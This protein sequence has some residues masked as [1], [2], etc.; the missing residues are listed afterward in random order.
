MS[1]VLQATL[2]PML[3]M[4]LCIVIGFIVNKKKLCPENTTTVLSKLENYVFSPALILNTFCRY[5]SISSIAQQYQMVLFSTLAVVLAIA[6]AYLLGPVFAKKGYTRS[7]YHYALTFGNFGFLGNAIVPAILGQD[8]LYTYMLFSLPLYVGVYTWGLTVLIPREKGQGNPF[9]NLLNPSMIAV[10]LGS[11]LGLTG[12]A[13][14]LPSFIT[15]T[16]STL[17]S[18]MGPVAMVLTGFVIGNYS[19]K[20]LLGQKK[21]YLATGLRLFILPALFVLLLKFLGADSITLTMCLFAFGTPLG[22]N[23]VVFPAAY[24]GDT[25]IG[26][27]MAMISHTASIITIPVMYA[28]LTAFI[29]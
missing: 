4:L 18:C 11:T 21:V 8:M 7:I 6:L 26:A 14:Y 19:F 20:T 24:G 15:D 13:A 17:G 25:V 5:C 1:A 23:T 9:K 10:V 3:V 22:L 12:A 28:L 16:L 29:L 2:W 27:S